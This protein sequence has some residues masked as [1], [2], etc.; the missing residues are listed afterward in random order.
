MIHV[1]PL[2]RLAETLERTRA[3][4]VV[5]LLSVG[6][7]FERPAHLSPGDCLHLAMHDIVEEREG[8]VAPAPEH[9]EALLDFARRWDRATPL[10]IHCY[11]GI[12]RST[13]AAYVIAAA[14]EPARDADDLAA[15]LRRLSPSATPNLRIVS[16]A[17]AILGRGGSLTRAI[18]AI[19]RG[20]EASEGVPFELRLSGCSPESS[21]AAA[22]PS[23]PLP[24]ASRAV[25]G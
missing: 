8:F 17:D 19:G 7:V 12:S 20:A 2:S 10:V 15:E 23:S 1:T 21:V 4:H 22:S 11:A 14:L 18:H 9:V 5:S 24:M 16:L 25:P 13:A 6:T 3:R